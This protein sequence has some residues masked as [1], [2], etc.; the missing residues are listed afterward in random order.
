LRLGNRQ[1][2]GPTTLSTGAAF[3]LRPRN[4]SAARIAAASLATRVPS[5]KRGF[6]V[7]HSGTALAKVKSRKLSAVMWP[8]STSSYAS[9]NGWRMSI[10]SKCPMS[11]LKITLSFDPNGLLRPNA[12]AFNAVVG[13]AAEIIG[14]GV[15]VDPVFLAGDL[16]GREIVD[17]VEIAGEVRLFGVG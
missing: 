3:R 12:V 7:S 1:H 13:L 10:T 9:S 17:V 14:L 4:Y 8:S 5:K 2:A 11:E 6:W 16:A 15:E